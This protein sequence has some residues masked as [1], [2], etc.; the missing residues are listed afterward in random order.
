MTLTH[1]ALTICFPERLQS[2]LDKIKAIFLDNG[3]PEHY[4]AGLGIV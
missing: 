4:V 1:R 2:E 3:Y